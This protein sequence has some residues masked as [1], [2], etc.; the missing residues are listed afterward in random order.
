MKNIYVN[1]G[2]S[3]IKSSSCERLLEIDRDFELSFGNYINQVCAKSRINIKALARIAPFLNKGK[4]KL[5]RNDFFKSQFS[6]CTLSWLFHSRTL[7][8]IKRLS[9]RCLLIIYN[10]NASS[11]TQLLGRDNSVF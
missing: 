11:F 8:K 7:S 5:P 1:T 10:N 6:Y 4:R 3:Q 2:I 9:E